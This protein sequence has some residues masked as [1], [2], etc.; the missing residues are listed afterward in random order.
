MGDARQKAKDR[1]YWLV[2][3]LAEVSGLTKERVRQIL[4]EKRVLR[5]DKVGQVWIVPFVEGE[6]WLEQR[7]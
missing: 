3:E 4:S 1:G 5:G 7:Q 2:T 6:R